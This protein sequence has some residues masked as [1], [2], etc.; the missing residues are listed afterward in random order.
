[1]FRIFS[2]R[3]RYSLG[4]LCTTPP[5]VVTK[6]FSLRT[7]LV[8]VLVHVNFSSHPSNRLSLQV[9]VSSPPHPLSFNLSR[10]PTGSR[11]ITSDQIV[12]NKFVFF[13]N[14]SAYRWMEITA[15]SDKF[16][17]CFARVV[18][19]Y[20]NFVPN[21]LDV[22][23]SASGKFLG[24]SSNSFSFL[25]LRTWKRIASRDHLSRK[26]VLVQKKKKKKKKRDQSIFEFIFH[27][28]L[29]TFA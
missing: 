28:P 21:I 27:L 11:T 6:Y 23:S 15:R 29:I 5:Q 20:C 3:S 13:L 1:M 26:P 25:L 18:F 4:Y 12:H 16:I 14:S 2:C 24:F 19:R 22:V 8:L 7:V 17:I 9:D 10:W